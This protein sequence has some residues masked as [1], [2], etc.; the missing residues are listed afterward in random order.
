MPI[1]NPKRSLLFESIMIVHPYS[2][3]WFRS[4]G[5][6]CLRWNLKVQPRRELQSFR[7]S[8]PLHPSLLC[9]ALPP[10]VRLVLWPSLRYPVAGFKGALERN[11]LA[12]LPVIHSLPFDF[13]F[14]L[15]KIAVPPLS[16]TV[17]SP[18]WFCFIEITRISTIFHVSSES[19]FGVCLY[20]RSCYRP[21]VTT[22]AR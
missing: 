16:P 4:S 22:R 13:L 6:R 7:S 11:P 18:Q 5:V 2:R 17:A 10:L 9:A 14:P 8:H 19:L 21:T 1:A 15:R 20:V 3:G 12:R